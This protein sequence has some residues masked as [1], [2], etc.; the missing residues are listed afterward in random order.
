V[1][2]PGHDAP[3][4]TS[5][6]P[7]IRPR[8]LTDAR[9]LRALAH[10]TRIALLE[11]IGLSGPLTATEAARI[12]GGSV[13]N[14]AYHLR[15]LAK[16][17]YVAEAEGGTGR[18][19]PWKLGAVY[20]NFGE[21]DTD[22]AASHAARALRDLAM[23]RS[24]GRSRHYEDNR[25]RYP[26]EVRRVSG[27]SQFVLFGTAV[28]VER[29]Q[30]EIANVLTRYLDRVGDPSVRPEGSIPYELLLLTHPFE[31]PGPPVQKG[32]PTT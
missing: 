4:P 23:D 12:V 15:T 11:A 20:V 27:S 24:L 13:P 29:V 6:D 19:R 18:E 2:D 26:D 16:Y 21:S 3:A 5:G 9:A 1:S 31:A 25:E 30:T 7:K 8:E 32:D 22:P 14:V 10:P 28:E 17:D